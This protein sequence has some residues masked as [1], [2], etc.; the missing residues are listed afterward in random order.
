[1]LSMCRGYNRSTRYK[2][3]P[4]PDGTQN[5]PRFLALHEYDTT[6]FPMDDVKKVV[7]SEWSKKIIAGAQKFERDSWQYLG[8]FGQTE[9][10]L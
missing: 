9:T 1:M 10:K 7:S 5:T 2:V 3:S 6:D 4:N 8:S